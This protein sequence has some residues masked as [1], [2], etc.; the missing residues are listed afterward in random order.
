[1]VIIVNIKYNYNLNYVQINIKLFYLRL[2]Q[3]DM[4]QVVGSAKFHALEVVDSAKFDNEVVFGDLTLDG[5]DLSIVCSGVFSVTSLATDSTTNTSVVF[6]GIDMSAV[7][8]VT[9]HSSTKNTALLAGVDDTVDSDGIVVLGHKDAAGNTVAHVQAGW[10][11]G[12]STL[13]FYGT[14]PIAQQTGV[15]VSAAGIHA[16]CVALGLFTA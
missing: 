10:V 7:E 11:G 12:A 13:G 3:K 2:L 4:S 14:A 15:A 9:I 8:E 16:A 6:T 5:E 1:M